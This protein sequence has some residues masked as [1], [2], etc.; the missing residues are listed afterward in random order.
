[1]QVLGEIVQGEGGKDEGVYRSEGQG[2]VGISCSGMM[3]ADG[4]SFDRVTS[5]GVPELSC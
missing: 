2:T 3:M 4:L 1:V 5:E